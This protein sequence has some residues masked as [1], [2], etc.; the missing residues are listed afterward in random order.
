[1]PPRLPTALALALTFTAAL[2]AGCG[3]EAPPPVETVAYTPPPPLK[4]FVSSYPLAYF[5]QKLGGD[6][7]ELFFPKS[8][9]PD[10][11]KWR[12]NSDEVA[13]FQAADLILIP[14]TDAAPWIANIDPPTSGQIIDLTAASIA[15]PALH[16]NEAPTLAAAVSDALETALAEIDLNSRPDPTETLQTLEADWK[17][18]ADQMNDR[19]SRIE[20]PVV[21]STPDLEPWARQHNLNFITFEL[22]PRFEI[23]PSIS[24]K[25]KFDL[26]KH[27]AKWIIWEAPPSDTINGELA[28]IGLDSIVLNPALTHPADPETDLAAITQSNLDAL[29]P[30]AT[31]EAKLIATTSTPAADTPTKVAAP[32]PRVPWKPGHYQDTIQPLIDKYCI[33]CHDALTNEGE[34]DFEEFASESDALHAPDLWENVSALL[35]MRDMPPRKEKNQPTE[36]ERTAMIDWVA[37]LTGHWAAGAMGVDPGKTTIRRLNKNEY[38]YTIRDLFGLR[39]RPADNFPEEPGGEAGFD[40]NAD[41]LFLPSLLMENYVEAAGIIVQA[42]YDDRTLRS[43]YLFAA[44]SGGTSPDAAARKVLEYW[45]T[46]AYRRP[47]DEEELNRLIAIFQHETKKKKR[48]DEAMKMPLL[49]ILISPNFLYR[50]EL[51]QNSSKPYPVDQFDLASRLSYFLWSSMPDQELIDLAKEEKLHDPDVLEAQVL[52]MLEDEKAKSLSMHFAGQWFK[53]EMLRSTANPD[54]VKYPVFTFDLRVLLYRESAAYFGHLIKENGSI[55]DLLDSDYAFLNDRLAKHYGIPGVSG[56]EI[57]KVSLDNPNRGG[58]LG[59]GSVLTATSMPLRT[60]PAARGNYILEDILGT[61]MPEPPMDVAMLPDDDREIETKTFRDALIQHR[62]D[63]NC[64]S[65]HEAIDPIG[66]GF[67]NYDAIG[68]WRTNQNGN[69]LDTQGTLP[70]GR[71]FSSPAEFKKILL[72][73]KDLF[74]HHM[75]EKTLGYAL[76]RELSPYDR[77]VVAQIAHQ[78]INDDYRIHRVFIEVA[79]STPFL[80]RRNDDFQPTK[81]KSIA[82]H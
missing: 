63:P 38:N 53:W 52:R 44:P 26:R 33:E 29:S 25:L 45:T 18:L 46:R 7:I 56:S 78:L 72:E 35:E 3:K 79:K 22:D 70:D 40:N 49:A 17:K 23:G 32:K 74:A 47:V 13:A 31:G 16:P 81:S 12:P 59:M 50:S 76:G 54:E 39:I 9:T 68:R 42:L 73:D 20:E 28:E 57:R 14:S 69:P 34:L 4:V 11:A 80:N 21:L 41:A 66:F 36:E 43:R 27:P 65:C 19:A 1:M 77:P 37:S 30:I 71:S 58:L 82:Q 62:E 2:L 55:L 8:I 6:D 24:I 5:A 64:K 61:P 75:A 15:S 67:E 10:P 51:E 60:S 48:Y